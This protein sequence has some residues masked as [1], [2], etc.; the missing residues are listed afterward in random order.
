MLLETRH[1]R[2]I[3]GIV[4]HGTLTRAASHLNITQS[5]LSHQLLELEA[6]LGTALFQRVGKRMIPTAAGRRLLAAAEETLP[7]LRQA[8]ESLR[9]LARGGEAVMRLATECYTCYHWLPRV[10]P[11]LLRQ[12]P[13]LDLQ[14][15]PEATRRPT[16]ALLDGAIDV[17]IV[18]TVEDDPRLRYQRLF[19]DEL[20][21]LVPPGHPL[22]ARKYL[23]AADLQGEHLLVFFNAPA[24]TAIYTTC[25]C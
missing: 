16:A 24:A 25:L 22:A 2:L 15:V 9:L 21:S 20:V 1:L 12:F 3:A 14:V 11:P 10:M 19:E 7:R 4:E 23:E 5:G 8:E 18:H 13:A 17:A 6:R